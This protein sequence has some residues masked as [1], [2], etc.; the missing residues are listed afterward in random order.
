MNDMKNMNRGAFGLILLLAIFILPQISAASFNPQ[1][2]QGTM[3]TILEAGTNF[4]TPFLEKIIGEYSSSEFF[5]SKILLLILL[6]LVLK[7]VLELTPLGDGNKKLSLLIAI[8]IS[9]IGIRFINENGLIEA[10]LIQYGTLSA[11]IMTALPL[12]IFFYFI[13]HTNIGSYGRKAFWI[14]Y[15]IIMG[16]LWISKFDK[17]NDVSNWI[18]GVTIGVIILLTLL[19]KSIHSYMGISG[20]KKFEKNSYRKEIREYKNE[21]LKL[22]DYLRKKII[23]YSEY[24]KEV[25][26][27]EKK[28]A[29]LSKE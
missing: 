27:I 8:I 3:N 15:M 25:E 6:T 9:I 13:H 14:M 23:P 18:Y 22:E 28:I 10:I 1:D 12:I 20:L 5:F 29:E 4:A 26:E 11:A 19:D 17:L 2:I 24:K 16:A 7:R 21:I